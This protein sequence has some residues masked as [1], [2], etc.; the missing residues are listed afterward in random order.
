MIKNSKIG[1]FLIFSDSLSSLVAI[2]EEN[3]TTHT[4]K[5]Y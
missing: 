5:R 2:Q 1:K 3:Q 4:Y